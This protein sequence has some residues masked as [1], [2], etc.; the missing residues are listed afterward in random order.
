MKTI[1]DEAGVTLT[2]VSRILNG[3]GEKYAPATRDRIQEIA[4]RH[5][6]RPN[7]LVRGMQTG[8]TD[9][10]GVMVP[11]SVFYSDIVRG[12]H[13]V[14]LQNQ[15]LM[16]LSWNERSQNSP[17][18]ALE[19]R[20]IHQ[21]VDRRVDGFILRP[22]TE[23]F[24][25]SYFEEIWERGIPLILVDREIK[26]VNTDFVGTDDETGGRLAAEYLTSL[27]H[28]TFVFVGT[29]NASTSVRREAGFRKTLKG[30][31]GCTCTQHVD[32]WGE[33]GRERFRALF[34]KKKKPSAVFCY[35]DD[36]A[37]V[38]I[39]LLSDLDLKV[40]E[41]VSVLGFGNTPGHDRHVS[42]STFEQQPMAIGRM[43]ANLYLERVNASER[44]NIQKR[45][46]QPSLIIRDSTRTVS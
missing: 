43:A 28:R 8:K 39:N 1:A 38:V 24:E 12:I 25:H 33:E 29:Q 18:E 3:K 13:E 4:S 17:E 27:G 26:R 36:L 16:M 35:N 34:Q 2:T 22:S 7:A 5:R 23:E 32:L 10:A 46:I 19:R 14:F 11:I 40:P 41:D 42:I 15:T 21:L 20:I 31:D 30:R 45:L 6:Y 37:E 9:T 44:G